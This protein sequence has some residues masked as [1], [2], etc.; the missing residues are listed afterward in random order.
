MRQKQPAAKFGR[1]W[2][3]KI[4]T[5]FILVSL[6]LVAVAVVGLVVLFAFG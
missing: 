2:T 5:G 4:L 3:E 6:A 1:P